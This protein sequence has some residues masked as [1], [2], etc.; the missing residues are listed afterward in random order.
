MFILQTSVDP[1]HRSQR[2]NGDP[3][4]AL[5]R[6][7]GSRRAAQLEEVESVEV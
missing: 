6:D 4:P 7:P 2:P 3:V 1:P 5:S